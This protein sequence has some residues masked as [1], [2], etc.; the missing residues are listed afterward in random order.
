M[1]YGQK[2]FYSILARLTL[3]GAYSFLSQYRL[4][5][6]GGYVLFILIS[7]PMMDRSPLKMIVCPSI[8]YLYWGVY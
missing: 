8:F 3:R 6:E 4:S 7:I 5:D 2:L 1:T